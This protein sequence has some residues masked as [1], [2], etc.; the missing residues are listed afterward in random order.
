MYYHLLYSYSG[1]FRRPRKLTESR[2]HLGGNSFITAQWNQKLFCISWA[3]MGKL[4]FMVF[5]A[6]KKKAIVW[7]RSSFFRSFWRIYSSDLEV[8]NVHHHKSWAGDYSRLS[9]FCLAKGPSRLWKEPCLPLP[10][11]VAC[12]PTE[13][14]VYHLV[15][16]TALISALCQV[17]WRALFPWLWSFLHHSEN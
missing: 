15:S 2:K 3:E 13:R 9:G 14:G 4:S 1:L 17:L 6:K 16:G 5:G 8:N 7:G 12:C 10:G 11:S